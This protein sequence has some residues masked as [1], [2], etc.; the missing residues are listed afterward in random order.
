[1]HPMQSPTHSQF[2]KDKSR[3]WGERG[4]A[5][6]LRNRQRV[7][8]ERFLHF[9]QQFKLKFFAINLSQVKYSSDKILNYF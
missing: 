1:M 4:D 3:R 2:Y 5:V 7:Q 6:M 9:T 8:P